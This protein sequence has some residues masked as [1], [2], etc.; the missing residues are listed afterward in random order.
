MWLVIISLSLV[1]AAACLIF[2]FTRINRF[3]FIQ[4]IEKKYS[5][6]VGKIVSAVL[7]GIALLSVT[8]LWGM[9]NAVVVFINLAVIWHVCDI[10][11][12]IVL[13][14]KKLTKTEIY[15]AGI[16]AVVLTIIYL[17]YGY[18]A[19]HNVVETNYTVSADRD[20]EPIKIALISDAHVGTTMDSGKFEEQIN[21]ISAGNPDVVLIVGDLIDDSTDEKNMIQTCKALGNCTAK[22][23]VYYAFGNHDKGYSSE[24]VRG[25]SLEEFT[26]CMKDNGVKILE[27]EA[28]NIG[29]DYCI[30]GRADKGNSERKDIKDLVGKAESD[31][32][33]IV[34]DHQPSDYEAEAAAGCDL[35]LSGHT[36][37]GQLIPITKV[38]E[39]IGV[40]DATYGYERRGKT[41]FI[42][43]SGIG[44]WE[45][46]FKS[47]CKAEYVMISVD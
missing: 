17:S 27:D 10:F 9:M 30:I 19:A 36:H 41:D 32:Y 7:I 40:N 44:D 22:Y 18:F 26:T 28:E 39:W 25:F 34:M 13:R 11:F 42:V 15:Y 43:S 2:L 29:D 31:R 21:K 33:T 6:T 20:I 24:D 35:V 4:C 5:L 45:I 12:Y 47:G 14:S 46:Q 3:F 16:A 1:V 37:G 8:L 23:G 38:G